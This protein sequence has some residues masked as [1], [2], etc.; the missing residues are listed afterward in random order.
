MRI[1]AGTINHG[2]GWQEGP[3]VLVPRGEVRWWRSRGYNAQPDDAAE[4]EWAAYQRRQ[5]KNRAALAA[6]EERRCK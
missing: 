5:A 4:Q 6:K 1:T 3:T 2:E